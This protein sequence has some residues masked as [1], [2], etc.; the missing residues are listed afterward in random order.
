[1]PSARRATVQRQPAR[2]P[3]GTFQRTIQPPRGTGGA[4]TRTITGVG[5]VTGARVAAKSS[6]CSAFATRWRRGGASPAQAA[7]LTVALQGLS[8]PLQAVQRWP[9]QEVVTGVDPAGQW[10]V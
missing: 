6:S 8:V 5:A 3:L 2:E 1:V 10:L 4:A 9:F 7:N